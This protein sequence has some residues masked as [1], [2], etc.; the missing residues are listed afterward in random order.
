MDAKTGVTAK[1]AIGNF[2]TWSDQ[3]KAYLMSKNIYQYVVGRK[4]TQ[5]LMYESAANDCASMTT[6]ERACLDKE[7][8]KDKIK[9]LMFLGGEDQQAKG[10]LLASITPEILHSLRTIR[11]N[12]GKKVLNTQNCE[13]VYDA[14]KKYVIL[15]EQS[16]ILVRK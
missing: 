5:G 9:Q 11:T 16:M 6:K 1:L 4:A 15:V 13:A 12:D 8:A 10:I 7:Q 14:L 3:L 2:A